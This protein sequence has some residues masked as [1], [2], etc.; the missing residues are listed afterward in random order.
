MTDTFM[1]RSGFLSQF[2]E[3]VNEDEEHNNMVLAEKVQFMSR[4][5]IDHMYELAA[6]Y[7]I[8][9][10]GPALLTL[11][12]H[13]DERCTELITQFL[14]NKSLFLKKQALEASKITRQ[15]KLIPAISELLNDPVPSIR[16]TA[17]EVLFD[18]ETENLEQSLQKL[19]M[20]NSWY[21]R[22]RLAT[23]IRKHDIGKEL[24][25]QLQ[26]DPNASV[27]TAAGHKNA[28]ELYTA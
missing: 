28:E 11:A 26:A 7:D 27:S 8:N 15:K 2:I 4:V 1:N 12:A 20:D 23:L 3:K 25:P 19:A 9:K 18:L 24:L 22:E 14:Q 16:L 10:K 21:I 5:A 6:G 13:R 17:M